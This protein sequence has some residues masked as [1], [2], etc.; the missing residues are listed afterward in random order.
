MPSWF[1]P[2]PLS[3]LAVR[4]E[5]GT[6]ATVSELDGEGMCVET[7]A[8]I[9]LG[10]SLTLKLCPPGSPV[11]FVATGTVTEVQTTSRCTRASLRFTDISLRDS[12]L[13]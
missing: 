11:A 9:A 4:F 6:E 13:A 1:S 7:S 5:D 3:G 8:S 12:L 2:P 10:D